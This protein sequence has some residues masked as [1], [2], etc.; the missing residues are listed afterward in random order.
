MSTSGTN[1]GNKDVVQALDLWSAGSQALR[2]AHDNKV[3]HCDIRRANFVKFST[4]WQLTD[5]GLAHKIADH[6]QAAYL[7]LEPGTG[8]ARG[9][10]IRL[11]GRT[12]PVAW[13]E[14]GQRPCGRSKVLH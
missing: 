1:Q 12:G 14:T 8:Q 3:L 7:T 4:G 2:L 9:V 5:Y 10:G 6:K 11:K 13:K